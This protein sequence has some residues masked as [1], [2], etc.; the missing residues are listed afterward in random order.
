MPGITTE[1]GRQPPNK[2][3]SNALGVLDLFA[4][5]SAPLGITEISKRVGL[6]KS[7]VSRIVATLTHHGYLDRSPDDRRYQVGA[8]AWLVG[9]GYRPGLLLAET[10]RVAMA[11]VLR[12]F[13][14]TTGYAA[15]LNGRE[16]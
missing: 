13:P 7:T 2:A 8:N 3:L 6:D 1:N 12:R 4:D 5:G 16:V 15:V 9:N 14:G 10:T 11:D